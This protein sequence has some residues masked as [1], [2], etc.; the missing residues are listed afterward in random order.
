MIPTPHPHPPSSSLTTLRRD[1][2][3]SKSSIETQERH[4]HRHHHHPATLEGIAQAMTPTKNDR[5]GLHRCTR[6]DRSWSVQGR[7]KHLLHPLRRLPASSRSVSSAPTPFR[8]KPLD[9][10]LHL[11][12]TTE[13]KQDKH[14]RDGVKDCAIMEIQDIERHRWSSILRRIIAGVE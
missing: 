13:D 9:H 1:S 6:I 5:Q 8:P 7:P 14:H 10:L 2:H 12:A 4:H 3:S 11:R